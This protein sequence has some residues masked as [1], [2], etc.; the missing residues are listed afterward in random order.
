MILEKLKKKLGTNS[1]KAIQCRLPAALVDQV[2]KNLKKKSVTLKSVI[3][4][5]LEIFCEECDRSRK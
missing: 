2:N 1:T 3:A 4:R 5:S